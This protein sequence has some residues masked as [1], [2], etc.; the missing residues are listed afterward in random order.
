[1]IVGPEA[2]LMLLEYNWPGNIRELLNVLERSILM[3]GNG[4]VLE[5]LIID[6]E[7]GGGERL[8]Q[9]L[10]AADLPDT[11]AAFKRFKSEAVRG[12][13][14]EMERLFIEKLLLRNNGNV[15]MS[16]RKA[17]IDRRQLQDM[18]KKLGIDTDLF[19]GARE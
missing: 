14:E 9:E 18:I 7:G 2:K 16:A 6:V 5:K 10:M 19:K 15:S 13:K 8:E 4:G 17:G 11:W 12:K 3:A 1:M